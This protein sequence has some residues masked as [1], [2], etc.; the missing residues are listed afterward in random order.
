MSFLIF[1]YK[2]YAHRSLAVLWHEDTFCPGRSSIKPV[3][4]VRNFNDRI[5]KKGQKKRSPDCPYRHIFTDTLSDSGTWMVSPNGCFYA[6]HHSARPKIN[7]PTAGAA[8]RDGPPFIPISCKASRSYPS[9]LLLAYLVCTTSNLSNE[10][11]YRR[12]RFPCDLKSHLSIGNR[13]SI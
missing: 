9:V 10:R 4:R 13:S 12:G 3:S 11:D 5:N 7:K 8:Y 1:T 6:I 2:K